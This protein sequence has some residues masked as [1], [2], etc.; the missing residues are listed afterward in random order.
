LVSLQLRP[1]SRDD[2]H[3]ITRLL[4]GDTELALR[5]AAV[6]IPYT[7]EHARIFL[8]RAD[9]RQIFAILAGTE[10]V[11][12]IGFKSESERIE[13]GYWIG[14]PY[15]G[16]GYATRAVR[17]LIEEARRRGI[18]RLHAEVF[19]DN[20][21]SMRVLEKCGFLRECEVERHLPQR[22]GLRRLVRFQLTLSTQAAC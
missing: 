7:I 17:L 16:R 19:P 18:E 2:D 14:R 22:G 9:P 6:P 3:A 15:W 8:Q 20:F 4:R 10:L 13:I 21:G 5:T 1:I 12:A 11:G